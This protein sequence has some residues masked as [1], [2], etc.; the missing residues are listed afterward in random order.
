M[1]KIITSIFLILI[2]FNTKAQKITGSWY[3]KVKISEE[4]TLEFNFYISKDSDNY[5]TIIDIPTNRVTGLK[6]KTTIFKNDTLFINGSNLGI[7]Y[8]GVVNWNTQKITGNFS[9]GGNTIPLSLEK[10]KEKPKAV[11]RKP[12]EPIKPYPYKE[13]DVSFK[14]NAAEVTLAAT[15]TKPNAKKKCPVV[16]L[17]T[18]SGPQD[19][20]QTFMG[21][22]TF[23][24]LAD[25]LTR[26]GIAVLRYDD[27]GTSEST[28]D[29]SAA[30]TEDFANDVVAAVNYLKTRDDVD[31]QN[32]GLIGHSEGGI[33]APL[34]ANKMKNDIA[35]IVSLAGTGIMGSELVYNQVIN[36]RAFPVPNE[37]AFNL[38]MRKAID[39]ASSSKDLPEIKL[40]LKEHY[41]KE[42]A[43]ILRPMLG[44]EERT[45]QII[46]G[47]IEARTTK[48]IRY[49]Y[50]YN[51][52]DEYAK[53]KIPVLS[54]NGSKD[55]QVPA[56]IHQEGIRKAL[57]KAGNEKSEI[58][59]LEGL[60]HLFQVAG[61]GKMDEYIKIDQTFSPNALKII[62]NWIL[63][64]IK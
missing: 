19:R 30:T 37:E 36:M 64:H 17:I 20:D 44:S 40:E 2:T 21:H 55:T 31:T 33:I 57:E 11:A 27:R 35:F 52:A 22:K 61:T 12:Q 1:R 38:S 41:T 39:I 54:L 8:E 26:Q 16:I 63:N 62:S 47:L 46:S 5:T 4:K 28:G 10:L 24:V 23:L 51:P 42:V 3:S 56:K 34:A 7:K 45:E 58:I 29:F 53:I 60:N 18:G 59:E 9:E 15:F 32:I 25:Y 48:W 14:N 6:P 43:P 49:F 13:E 50:N